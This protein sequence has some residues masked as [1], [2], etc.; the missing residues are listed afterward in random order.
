[1]GKIRKTY[2]VEFKLEV[3]QKYLSE[4]WSQSMI[5][6]HYR[7]YNSMLQRWVNDY[8]QEGVEGLKEKRGTSKG[9]QKGRPRKN[10]L[11][12]KEKIIRLEAEVE[13]LKKLL[14]VRKGE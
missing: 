12:D 10:P 3:V 13:F 4:G 7:V 9:K 14:K 11:S 8:R 1:M 5:L 2:S 6:D